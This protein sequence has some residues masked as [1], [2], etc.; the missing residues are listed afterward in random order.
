MVSVLRIPL[1]LK[2]N[3]FAVDLVHAKKLNYSLTIHEI[4]IFEGEAKVLKRFLASLL[5][6]KLRH[7][8]YPKESMNTA[9]RQEYLDR[10]NST[11]GFQELLGQ[12]LR[13][14]DIKP[15]NALRKD[16]KR[17][18]CAFLG[19]F[20]LNLNTNSG[21][22]IFVDDYSQL[23]RLINSN[24]VLDLED[25]GPVMH[26]TQRCKKSRLSLK[27]NVML[28]VFITAY[29]RV[30][31]HSDLLRLVNIG[32]TLYRQAYCCAAIFVRATTKIT[33]R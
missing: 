2:T 31:I 16:L 32:A 9:E 8:P 3:F 27:S 10:L 23:A 20:S 12:K 13:Q 30:Q 5:L 17:K 33:T 24:C 29:A 6:Q 26:V 7:S 18:I 21:T 28:G 4:A 25:Y 15:N 19:F 14:E 22:S 1:P 11:I